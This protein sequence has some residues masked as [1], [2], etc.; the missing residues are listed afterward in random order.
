MNKLKEINAYM[1]LT[2]DK[3]PSIRADLVRLDDNWQE[4]D[5]AKQV[6]SL[7]RLAERKPKNILN[8]DQK[9]KRESVFQTKEQKQCVCVYC[10]KQRHKASQCESV[11]SVE[12]RRLIL[13]KKK[14]CFN[15]TGT[16]HKASDCHSNKLWLICNSKHHASI[17]DKNEN[18]LF[19]TNSNACTCLLV[20]VNIERLKCCALVDTGTGSFY[21]SST[22]ISLLNQKSNKKPIRTESKKTETLVNSS[23]EIQDIHN[24][25]SFKTE[26]SKLEKSVL[27]ELPN[28]NYREE[29]NNY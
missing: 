14:L 26:I 20:I 24:E 29:Q 11:K 28:Q 4:W 6:D 10:D 17:C 18:A 21:V 3:L 16:K 9:H 5:F 12:D 23:M 1:K 19:K 7:R 8:N 27:L 25:F 22:I 15:C 13:S 2:L